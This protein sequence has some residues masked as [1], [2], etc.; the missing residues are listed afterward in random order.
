MGISPK[1]TLQSF[2]VA[3][4]ALVITACGGGSDDSTPAAATP[5]TP[6]FKLTSTAF[7]E[8]SKIP[9]EYA[10]E[11]KGGMNRSVPLAWS[12]VPANTSKYAV[13]M[14]DEVSPCETGDNAC[15]HWNVY[16]IPNTITSFTTGQK[17]TDINGV[18]EGKVQTG[19]TSFAN[20]YN[21]MCPPSKH[22]YKITAYALKDTMPIVDA[23]ASLTR[24]QFKSQ[25][26]SHILGEATLSGT[27]DPIAP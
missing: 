1:K 19:A 13:I 25:Y 6:S 14:D 12:E 20:A 23:S 21:G 22:T 4:L 8:G 18:V 24:S 3:M 2:S 15:K 17:V 9:V 11:D 26:S 7:V 27:F 10:C 5:T 16:N